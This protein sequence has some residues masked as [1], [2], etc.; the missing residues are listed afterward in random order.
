[1]PNARL[2]INFSSS[3]RTK[4][5]NENTLKPN[6]KQWWPVARPLVHAIATVYAMH[7]VHATGT[8]YVN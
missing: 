8:I 5:G 2:A 6:Q 3:L 4:V 1:M 7:I